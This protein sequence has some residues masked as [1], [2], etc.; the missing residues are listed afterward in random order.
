MQ[1]VTS[2]EVQSTHTRIHEASSKRSTRPCIA[3]ATWP[4]KRGRPAQMTSEECLQRA[5]GNKGLKKQRLG[6]SASCSS[7]SCA[8]MHSLCPGQKHHQ[9]TGNRAPQKLR[10]GM[11]RSGG[12]VFYME[13]LNNACIAIQQPDPRSK[14]MWRTLWG[15]ARHTSSRVFLESMSRTHARRCTP[16]GNSPDGRSARPRS[17]AALASPMACIADSHRRMLD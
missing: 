12:G 6:S 3:P 11:L 14:R 16:H 13:Q 17:I 10:A 2:S 7:P 5:L 9:S 8:A 1:S 15:L 4:T